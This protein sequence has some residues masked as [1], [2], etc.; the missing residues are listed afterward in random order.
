MS[1]QTEQTSSRSRWLR[2]GEPVAWTAFLMVIVVMQWPMVKGWYYRATGSAAPAAIEWR[3][4]FD[5]ALA[6]SRATGRQLLV[7]FNADWCP[8]CIAMKHDTWPD[9]EVVSLISEFYVPLLIDIDQDTIVSARYEVEAIPTI[10]VLD[11]AGEVAAR[12]GYLPASGMRRLLR[13]QLQ[14]R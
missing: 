12:A 7:D 11:G 3:T 2:R 10:L 6:E 5:A 1:G 9:P 13:E 4:D 14:K 8:P